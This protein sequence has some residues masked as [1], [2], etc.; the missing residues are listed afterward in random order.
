[1]CNIS[2]RYF[3]LAPGLAFSLAL[4]IIFMKTIG[5]IQV[6]IPTAPELIQDMLVTTGT[7]LSVR[8]IC[9]AGALIGVRE[10]A[11]RVG[12][13][14]LL[15]Q[16]KITSSA[17]GFYAMNT[18]ETALS[19]I[20][21]DWQHETV[22]TVPWDGTWLGAQDASV[23]RSDKTAWRHHNLALSL[24]GFRQLQTGLHVRPNNLT[25]GV[26]EI[27]DRL[28]ELGLSP[29]SMVF[30]LD[31]LDSERQNQALALWE[32]K[33]LGNEYQQIQKALRNSSSKFKKSDLDTMVRESLLLGR[34]VIK[35]LVRDPLLPAEIVPVTVRQAL[36]DEMKTYHANAQAYWYEWFSL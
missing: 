19:R 8:N 18:S 31:S 1:M 10:S 25:G 13:N 22:R 34:A 17:R 6:E 26:D 29:Q 20:I 33:S 14:R 21:D 35:R 36:T 32:V 15:E 23:L 2:L 7:A 11:I 27:R 30:R 28:N 12:L 5:N 16:G 4:N 3:A 9:R 24:C